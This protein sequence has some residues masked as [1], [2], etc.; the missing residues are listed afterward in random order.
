MKFKNDLKKIYSNF[1]LSSYDRDSEIDFAIYCIS[2]LKIKDFILGKLPN[3]IQKAEIEKVLEQRVKTGKPIQQI[4]GKA[5]FAGD[6]FIV[7]ENT[8][9]PRPE[10]E[11]LIKE[12]KSFFPQNA[13]I[14]ILDIGTG[15]GCISVELAKH[16]F[17]SKITAVDICQET[18]DTA[19]LNIKKHNLQD[20]ITLCQSDVYKNVSEKFDLIVSNP[21]YI[22]FQ[23]KSNVQKDVY[24]FEP[25]TALFAKNNGLFFYEEI[26]QNADNFLTKNGFLV[27]EIGINQAQSVTDIFL[28]NKFS[29]ISVTKD[30][31]NIERIISAQ[32]L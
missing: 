26:I 4:T 30:F 27:F 16:F 19:A 14:K 9:I 28:K 10:T 22:P 29:N 32:Y 17:K 18:L 7:N 21:P 2:G 15:S 8:L 6:E 1:D 23:D 11:F 24:K 3:D 12:C 31:N 5:F 20:R 13:T 25:H